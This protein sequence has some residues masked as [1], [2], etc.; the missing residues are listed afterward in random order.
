MPKHSDVASGTAEYTAA[1]EMRQAAHFTHS[2]AQPLALMAF[3]RTLALGRRGAQSFAGTFVLIGLRLGAPQQR[4]CW[5]ESS[6]TPSRRGMQPY[7]ETTGLSPTSTPAIGKGLECTAHTRAG[8]GLSWGQSSPPSF[9]P[10]GHLTGG[11]SSPPSFLPIGH[12]T[13]TG[14]L[15]GDG[16]ASLIQLLSEVLYYNAP[17]RR[18]CN[19]MPPRLRCPHLHD[20]LEGLRHRLPLLSGPTLHCATHTDNHSFVAARVGWRGDAA[21]GVSSSPSLYAAI[22]AMGAGGGFLH[23][24]NLGPPIPPLGGGLLR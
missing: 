1:E 4:R 13:G 3:P 5:E 6:P 7:P 18:S 16:I 12:L 20:L 14:H 9:L 17:C 24:L 21:A 15:P 2:L 19:I 11:Q 22:G 10:I 23:P 8:Q